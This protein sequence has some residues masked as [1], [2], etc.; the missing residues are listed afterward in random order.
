MTRRT[1]LALVAV[2]AVL[3]AA[4]G[5]IAGQQI[6]SPAEVA[7]DAAAP[8]ASLI[9]VPVEQRA[10][11]SNIVVRGQA[12]FDDATD[13]TVSGSAFGET[14]ITRVTKNMGEQLVEGDVVVEVAG[15]PVIVLQGDLP[16]F[17]TLTP[18][19]EGPDVLQLEEA[20]IRLGFNPGTVDGTFDT[21]TEDAVDGLYRLLGY[22]PDE[23]TADELASLKSAR[24]SVAQ[25]SSSVSQAQQAVND[26]GLPESQRLEI[27][28]H[29]RLSTDARDDVV[30]QSILDKAE[31]AGVTADAQTVFDAAVAATT[32]ATDRLLA[33]EG[34]THPDTGVAPTADELVVLQQAATDTTA[35]QAAALVVLDT[36]KADEAEV[37]IGVDRT[38][39]DAE[40][41]LAIAV[42]SRN[43]ALSPT[44]ATQARQQLSDAQGQLSDAREALAD[45]E[46][47]VGVE[48]PINELMFMPSLPRDIQRVNVE[49]GDIPQGAV[50]R[51]TGSGVVV[52]SAVSAADRPLIVEGAQAVMEND[53]LGISIAATVTF[54]AT[55]PGGADVS[56]DRYSVRFEPN[57]AVPEAGFDQNYRITIPIE[58]TGEDTLVVP[59]AALSA[60]ADGTA[61]VE[62]ETS[63]GVTE[64]VE[65]ATGLSA[66]GFVEV[67]ALGGF[68]LASGDRVVV[69]RDSVR[70]TGEDS[71]GE[72]SDG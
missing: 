2:V 71:A 67:T 10:L 47:I 70:V 21:N 51:V 63:V 56:S 60:G 36:A 53:D 22:T 41:D 16:A 59:L 25:A 29:V 37:V 35:A 68:D 7:A 64:L 46:A 72:D 52:R 15:R 61:R 31:V 26:S 33:A 12:Q 48:F 6:K 43:E 11:S 4:V 28:R 18:G 54:V 62:V 44:S 50:M 49:A 19:L 17:R 32:S 34:G 69:G 58:S 39:A 9:T 5:W 30:A 8:T 1:I 20:L 55:A 27:D 42:A 13:I 45:L 14:I 38:V 23:P 66:Q 40:T 65:V 24:D 57:E 3:S